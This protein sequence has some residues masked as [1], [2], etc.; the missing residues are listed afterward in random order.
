MPNTKG[1]DNTEN[2]QF[3]Y[4]FDIEIIVGDTTIK[5]IRLVSVTEVENYHD[6]FLASM[7]IDFMVSRKDMITIYDNQLKTI[8]HVIKTSNQYKPSQD[9]PTASASGASPPFG[10]SLELV[11]QTKELDELFIPLFDD[12]TFVQ[13]LDEADLNDPTGTD[14][15][16]MSSK[17]VNVLPVTLN[18]LMYSRTAIRSN[19]SALINAV[20]N[21][22]DPATALAWI[23]TNSGVKSA[24][25]DTPDNT[26]QESNIIL[27][28]YNLRN[29]L[30]AL[31]A[32]YGLYNDS[33]LAFLD[34][35]RLYVLK[36]FGADHD[37]EDGD[38]PYTNITIYDPP[39]TNIGIARIQETATAY[40]YSITTSVRKGDL[41][42]LAGEIIGSKVL[43]T[44]LQIAINSISAESGNIV[45]YNA[46]ARAIA[47]QVDSHTDSGDKITF[48]YDE[49]N[50]LTAMAGFMRESSLKTTVAFD[51]PGVNSLSI[52]PNKIFT[53]A[54][55]NVTKQQK[56]GGKYTPTSAVI[57]YH[58]VNPVTV[59]FAGNASLKL[60]TLKED[61]G[62]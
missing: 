17:V 5:P 4:S 11:S 28:P 33:L 61:K 47:R 22:C 38:K 44:N 29:S 23:V 39:G 14:E 62:S 21:K 57:H 12:K 19:K 26:Q 31:Q 15:S 45:G 60:V 50:N 36:K 1:L 54:F 49:L 3:R 42:A 56:L 58:I 16:G 18:A 2:Y 43:T 13:N 40:N 52:K 7:E 59:E 20:F 34:F 32:Y 6:S 27:L 30:Y 55:D 25:V 8:I 46:A 41:R 51:I 9:Q 37:Y 48:E 35:D 10:D 53:L 24:I